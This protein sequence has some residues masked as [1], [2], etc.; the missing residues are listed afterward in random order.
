MVQHTGTYFI[1]GPSLVS[2]KQLPL[3]QHRLDDLHPLNF[4]ISDFSLD[5]LTYPSPLK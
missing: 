2:M 3:V 1:H 5:L 4:E